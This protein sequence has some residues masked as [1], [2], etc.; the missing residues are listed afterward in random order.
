M[1][2]VLVVFQ[3]GIR[4]PIGTRSIFLEFIQ[5]EKVM[6]PGLMFITKIVYVH[7]EL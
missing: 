2:L 1:R 4:A 3:I 6:V 5:I 7:G